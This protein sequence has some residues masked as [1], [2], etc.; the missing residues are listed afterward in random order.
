MG[1]ARDGSL[2]AEVPPPSL[3][4]EAT[5]EPPAP[6]QGLSPPAEAGGRSQ[7]LALLVKSHLFKPSLF[8]FFPNQMESS[9]KDA[10]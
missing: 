5:L 10:K 3:P 1:G 9:S 7:A 6:S 4:R 8:F 2:A